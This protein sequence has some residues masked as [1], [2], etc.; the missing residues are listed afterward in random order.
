MPKLN[1]V[2][3]PLGRGGGKR[4]KC[5]MLIVYHV[6]S[7]LQHLK[8]AMPKAKLKTKFVVFVYFPFT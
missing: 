3:F 5:E 1:G 4:V 8:K 6:A 7:V 2:N